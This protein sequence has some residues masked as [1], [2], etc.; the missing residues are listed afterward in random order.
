MT[1]TGQAKVQG[2]YHHGNLRAALLAAAVD[3]V[4]E[5]GPAALTLSQASRR[6]G[7]S[8]NAAYHHFEGLSGSGVPWLTSAS[9]H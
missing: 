4:R 6:V 3:L 1:A 5:S 9:P 8:A 2:A 7:V